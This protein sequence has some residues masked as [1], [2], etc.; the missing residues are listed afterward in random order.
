MYITM[1]LDIDNQIRSLAASLDTD[2]YGVAD[3]SPARDF[4][5]TQGGERTSKYPRGVVAGIRLQDSVVDLLPEKDKEGAILYRHTAYDVVNTALD[6]VALRIANTLQ[7]EGYEAFPVP[8]S[9]R[10]DD[11]N[12]CGIFSQ[13]LAAHIAGLGWIGKSCLLVT[14]E[15][16]PR[17]RWVTVLTNAPLRPTGISVEPRCGECTACVDICPVHAFTGKPFSPD[18][19]REA[20][21]DATACDRYFK[22]LEKEQGIAGVCGLCIWVCPYGRKKGRRA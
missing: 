3:L 20:R 12:I 7:R 6:Q 10:T 22:K 14:P 5:R 8:A 4:I 1:H 16:G 17:V 19:P 18:E 15:H 2:Y 21:F 13:K 11:E 9:K